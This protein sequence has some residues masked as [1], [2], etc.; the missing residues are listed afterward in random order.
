MML[1]KR[2]GKWMI[3]VREDQG[4]LS[5]VSRCERIMQ[6]DDIGVYDGLPWVDRANRVLVG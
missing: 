6:R 1:G 4:R 3:V 5:E 2:L